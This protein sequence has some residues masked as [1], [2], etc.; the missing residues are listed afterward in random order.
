MC[1]RVLAPHDAVWDQRENENR[2]AARRRIARGGKEADDMTRA[3][4]PARARAEIA[5]ELRVSIASAA[6]IVTARQKG[7]ELAMKLGFSG[8]EVTVIAAAISEIARNIVDYAQCGE[9]AMGA[10]EGR[11][12]RGIGI[13]ARDDGP[14]IADVAQAMLY[15]Y[16]SGKKQG[17]GLPGAKWLMDEFEITSKPRKG[18]TVVMKKWL[19]DS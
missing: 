12:R 9:M 6:D 8:A 2:M 10:V 1:P 13:I 14:G 5:V 18:T 7:R 3:I 11:S 17:V 16:S 19:S 15:G 4:K